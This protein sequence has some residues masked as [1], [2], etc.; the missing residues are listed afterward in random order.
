MLKGFIK[1]QLTKWGYDIVKLNK[2]DRWPIDFEEAHKKIIQK[3]RPY[4]MTS[5]ERIFGLVEAVK[6]L[7]KNNIQG[8]IVECGVWKGGS[9]LAIAEALITMNEKNRDLYLYDTY[10]GM[11]QPTEHDVNFTDQKAQDL[12][13]TDKNKEE[14]FV[15]AYST[16]ETVK[17]TM[18]LTIYPENKVH[19]I[20]GKVE[21]SIPSTL[22]GRIA[23]LR[24]DTDWY[25]STRHE[26]IY[27]FPLLVKG[28][29]LII[30]DYG[31]WK[32]ARKAVD[33]YIN[34]NKIQILLNRLDDTGRIGVKLNS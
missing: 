29:I 31:F 12:L 16:L 21:D 24:L 22:P 20:K 11:S 2:A 15:W 13:T 28:G 26:L 10:E 5:H 1:K 23:L 14:N 9:M 4:T 32:G 30:D 27:L 7:A 19:Y 25:E 3:V 34:D 17:Q 6:Y 33:E 18:S 8:D